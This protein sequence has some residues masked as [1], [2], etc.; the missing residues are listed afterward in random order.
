MKNLG[1]AVVLLSVFLLMGCKVQNVNDS[2]NNKPNP[3][4]FHG[5]KGVG[6]NPGWSL[7][8]SDSNLV[9]KHTKQSQKQVYK[10]LR[11]IP[12]QDVAGIH[13]TAYNELGN[14][15]QVKIFK[16]DCKDATAKKTWPA[17]VEVTVETGKSA[18]DKMETNLHGCG[19]FVDEGLVGTWM[20]KSLNGKKIK[21][22]ET[23]GKNPQVTFKDGNIGA[24]MGCN[25]MGGSF[26]L[27][28]NA[29]YI[30]KN[31]IS[32]LLFC[33]NKM[34]LEDEFSQSVAGKG[35]KYSFAFGDLILSDFNN[36]VIMKLR[37][38]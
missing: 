33:E 3:E 19:A 20:L 4:A 32:T 21:G 7:L 27:W 24:N 38:N 37:K 6:N 31:F 25:S 11:V 23:E 16:E 15:I 5:F 13:Y 26:T 35:F 12:I 10:K 8:I 34:K 22:K 18:A 29:I 9:F 36:N 30:N 2:N 1:I 28:N 17:R 14:K